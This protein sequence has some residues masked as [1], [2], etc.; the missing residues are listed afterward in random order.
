MARFQVTAPD[1][2]MV[3]LEGDKPPTDADLEPIFASLPP[4]KTGIDPIGMMAAGPT[5]FGASPDVHHLS[6]IPGA[7]NRSAILGMNPLE[8]EKNPENVPSIQSKI[9]PALAQATGYNKLPEPVRFGIEHTPIVQSARANVFGAPD[10]ITDPV[11]MGIMAAGGKVMESPAFGKAMSE[12]SSTKFGGIPKTTAAEALDITE[13]EKVPIRNLKERFGE[14]AHVSTQWVGANQGEYVNTHA[15]EPVNLT[16]LQRAVEESPIKVQQSIF[17]DPELDRI[18][19]MVS[20]TLKNAE[21]IR[22]HIREH[23]NNVDFMSKAPLQKIYNDVG[24]V[25][26]ENHPG[27][28]DLMRGYGETKAAEESLVGKVTEPRMRNIFGK[29][30]MPEDVSEELKI[31]REQNPEVGEAATDIRKFGETQNRNRA[32][33]KI[34]K[35]VG[36]GAAYSAPFGAGYAV[37]KIFGHHYK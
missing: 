7:I 27:L 5:A 2:R 32:L 8:A 30:T 16:K 15:N 26:T 37:N 23:M 33:G 14:Q 1:G 24:D 29:K 25:M 6:K 28:N 17:E 22:G 18:G 31:L 19:D 4:K 34:A 12:I 11:Q 36:Y 10:V 13:A 35:R 9:E 20:P 3:T 21:R